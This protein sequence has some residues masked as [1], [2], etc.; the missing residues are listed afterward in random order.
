[1]TD[2][3]RHLPHSHPNDAYLFVTWRLEGSLPA[4]V[5]DVIYATPGHRFAAEDRELARAKG[6]RW[7][8]DT[9]VATCLAEILQAGER[10]NLYEL[11]AW[12]I[13]ANHVHILILPKSDPVK[14][15]HWIKGRSAK[16]ANSLL[17]LTGQFW[18]HESY[19]HFVRSR[20]EFFRIAN[21]I[22]QNPVAAGLVSDAGDWRFSSAS[23]LDRLKHVPQE[24]DDDVK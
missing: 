2:Y 23:Y 14:L 13:M 24:E 18:Q 16:D 21:Y 6:P 17:G 4:E 7:L 5:P 1:V 3:Q 15:M 22:E 8:T 10:K 19:D 12:V 20:L 11:C 9:R